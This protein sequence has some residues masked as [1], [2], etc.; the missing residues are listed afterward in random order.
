MNVYTHTNLPKD[1]WI[2]GC[3]NCARKT[4]V[5][6][7]YKYKDNFHVVYLCNFCYKDSRVATNRAPI[8]N[9]IQTKINNYID[10]NTFQPYQARVYKLE[11]PCLKNYIKTKL[12]PMADVVTEKKE[13]TVQEDR[14]FDIL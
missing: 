11:P 4:A 10:D 6:I 12:N 7:N 5:T 3:I 8:D 14:I 13:N 1:G 9:T 2:Q